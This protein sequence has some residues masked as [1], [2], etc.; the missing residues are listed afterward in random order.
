M[1]FS[2]EANICLP[3]IF[4][5]D[6]SESQNISRAIILFRKISNFASTLLVAL[7]HCSN[8]YGYNLLYTMY[9]TIFSL[10]KT[11]LKSGGSLIYSRCTHA[12]GVC[13]I[14]SIS[15]FFKVSPMTLKLRILSSSMV[16]R[17]T[18]FNCIYF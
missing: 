10:I 17:Y 3:V 12:V 18:N 1:N 4:H 16:S 11:H 2:T 8:V 13:F 5:W 6:V 7:S 9:R 14:H 15:C